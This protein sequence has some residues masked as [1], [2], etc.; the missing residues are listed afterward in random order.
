MSVILLFPM[1]LLILLVVSVA[2]LSSA[3]LSII[4]TTLITSLVWCCVV[5]KM[6]KKN[7]VNADSHAISSQQETILTFQGNISLQENVAYGQVGSRIR[8]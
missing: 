4:G 7:D 8:K 5:I 2:V 1:S 3:V 6:M